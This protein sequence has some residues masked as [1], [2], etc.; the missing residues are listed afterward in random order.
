MSKVPIAYT[1]AQAVAVEL[2]ERLRPA[3]ERLQI[4]GSLR[5][6]AATVGDL[7]IVCIPRLA[8]ELDL[9]GEPS[10]RPV[11]LVDVA[12]RELGGVRTKDGPRF[13]QFAFR[14]LPVDLFLVKPETWGV[15]LALRTGSA[16]FSHWLVTACRQGG[17]RPD[18]LLIREGRVWRP[19]GGMLETPEER[20]VFAALG[21]AWLE[22]QA[23]VAGRWWQQATRRAPLAGEVVP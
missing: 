18:T 21:L 7:E 22:P 9:F 19:D 5:R 8:W 3:C 15:Q 4:A 11:D 17:A 20:D 13:K 10:G 2:C 6:Q 23:R 1:A 12:L 14:G 16:D